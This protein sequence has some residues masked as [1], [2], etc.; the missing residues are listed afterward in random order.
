MGPRRCIRAASPKL[1]GFSGC[2][3]DVPPR[4]ARKT[5]L[6]LADR[7]AEERFYVD[8]YLSQS[9]EPVA[10]TFLPRQAGDIN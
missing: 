8:G 3:H 9:T 2:A 1:R 6:Q 7:A 4:I 10:G 5:R